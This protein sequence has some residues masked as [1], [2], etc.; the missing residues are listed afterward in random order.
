MTE[1][2]DKLQPD[3]HSQFQ[4]WR[5]ANPDGYF[6]NPKSGRNNYMLHHVS[7]RHIGNDTWEPEDYDGETIT[8][9]P[10]R[11]STDEKELK[12]WADKNGF[13]VTDCRDC[14]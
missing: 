11:C 8:R 2:C 3:A 9:K 14:I 4:A 12:A 6:L 7:C 5:R 10:K 1:F 13:A